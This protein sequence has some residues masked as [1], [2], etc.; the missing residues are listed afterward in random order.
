MKKI[1]NMFFPLIAG[2]TIVGLTINFSACSEQSPLQVENG[3]S[4]LSLAKGSIL[5]QFASSNFSYLN[6]SLGYEGGDIMLSDGTIFHIEPGAMVPPE[7]T[8]NGEN[9][10]L[11]M[12]VERRE[13]QK[14]GREIRFTFGPDGC[15]FDPPAEVELGWFKRGSSKPKLYYIDENGNYIEQPP[16]DVELLGN[17]LKLYI[18]HFSGYSLDDE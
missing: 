5:P 17:R 2:V 1:R 14:G 6:E 10:S 13:S 8:P 15:R 11:T 16:D 9:L 3:N 7:G 18:R 4:N 12:S